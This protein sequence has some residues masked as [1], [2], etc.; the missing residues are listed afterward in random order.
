MLAKECV[1]IS[2]RD[3]G[4]GIDHKKLMTLFSVEH[5]HSSLGTDGETGSGLGL[6]ISREFIEELGG[7]LWVESKEASGTTVYLELPAFLEKQSL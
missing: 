6:I 2:V 5:K 7:S 4:T 1:L 3:E